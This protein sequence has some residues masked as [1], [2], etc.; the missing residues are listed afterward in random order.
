MNVTRRELPAFLAVAQATSASSRP[1]QGFPQQD[2]AWAKE[3]V[4]AA[5]SDLARVKAVVDAHPAAANAVID[6]GFGDWESGLGAAAHMGR[7]DIAEYLLS[8]GARLDLFAAAMLGMTDAVK[9]MVAARPGVEASLGPHGI[10]L[11]AHARAGGERARETLA[12]LE[13]L[14]GASKGSPTPPLD[15]ERRRV[16]VGTYQFDGGPKAEIRLSSPNQLSLVIDGAQ[17][18][19]I[20]HAGNEAFYPA[21]VPKVRIEFGLQD[22][23]PVSLR[24]VDG[25]AV[26]SAQRI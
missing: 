18:R 9:H 14:P 16:F 24:I 12:Y 4:L 7:R 6:W 11:I 21:G 22:G 26:A 19:W 25:P 5:H 8:M 20:H 23:R 2:Y 10:P 13:S 15:A 1:W 3:V 17:P